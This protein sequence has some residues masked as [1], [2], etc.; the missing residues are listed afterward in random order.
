[1]MER[2]V[3]LV[4]GLKVMVLLMVVVVVV[5]LGQRMELVLH[6]ELVPFQVWQQGPLCSHLFLLFEFLE[7]FADWMVHR[8]GECHLVFLVSPLLLLL[9]HI[10]DFTEDNL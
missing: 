1:M 4:L 2:V 3:H 6:M 8:N 9:L 7:E 10:R 5:V